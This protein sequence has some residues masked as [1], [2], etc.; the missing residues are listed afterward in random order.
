MRIHTSH[1]GYDI[2]AFK[3]AV[4]GELAVGE[5]PH[6][7]LVRV[8]ADAV[9]DYADARAAASAPAASGGIIEARVTPATEV[10]HW[11]G[12]A[13]AAVDF[14]E[15]DVPGT[16]LIEATSGG[17]T[18]RSEPFEI[19]IERVHAQGMSDVLFAF[20]AVRSSGEIERKDAAAALWGAEPDAPTVDARGGWLDASG[21]T[22]KFLSHLTYSPTMSPQ[23]IPLCAWA[24]LEAR[25]G[26]A[27]FHPR[28]SRVLGA[29]L[30]DEALFGADFLIRFRDPRGRFYSGIFD[31]LTKSLPE[32]IINAPLPECVRTDRYIASYRGGGGLAIAA[33]A[34]ASRESEHGEFDQAAYLSAARTAFLDLEAHNDEYL[35]GLD[36]ASGELTPSS[37]SIVD[38][39]CA[40]L[41]ATELH[42]ADPRPEYAEAVATR[43]ANIEGR[44]RA[45]SPGWFEAW[46]DGRPH[47]S[48]VEPGLLP[49]ALLRAAEVFEEDEI[50]ERAR[51]LAVTA[52]SDLIVRTD[53]VPNPFGYPRQRVQPRGGEARDAFF[54]PHEND[55]GY[56]WQGE[57]AAL[58]SLSHAA[59]RVAELPGVPESLRERLRRFAVDQVHWMVGRNPFDVC[60]LQ[61]RGR[62]NA[63]YTPDFPNLPGGI[64]N[65]ITSGLDDENGIDFRTGTAAGHDSWRWTEQWI[66]HSAWYLLALSTLPTAA[67]G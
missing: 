47:F 27:R 8:D 30:R 14:S 65:G 3:R 17:L 26:L 61:G 28:F 5:R 41:A 56:W 51:T 29:R 64:V 13:Y 45:G 63:E 7:R 32:R 58:G 22:S 9:A 21:D 57:N 33:L 20:K 37:E 12:G 54:F 19:G 36:L 46:E 62:N 52:M 49:I 55:T 66:P 34:R 40:L 43:L 44:H 4:I 39:Y 35:F 11:A 6:V 16:Y 59:A 23:Q 48:P 31:G 67:A 18:G 60:M 10:D 50:S 15:V 1:L 24:F 38:D 25:D 2:G 42:A 53:A